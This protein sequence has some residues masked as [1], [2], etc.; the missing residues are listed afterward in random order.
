ML[1]P[2]VLVAAVVAA[3]VVYQAWLKYRAERPKVLA[4]SATALAGTVDKRLQ[5]L[6]D[7]QDE[8]IA[9]LRRMLDDSGEL[10]D[11]QQG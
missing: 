4:D 5:M 7:S 11:G 2:T 6:L 9:R 10:E 3:Q 8:E 1:D